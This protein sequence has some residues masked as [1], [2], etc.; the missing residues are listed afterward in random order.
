M[1][2]IIIILLIILVFYI[3]YDNYKKDRFINSLK[4]KITDPVPDQSPQTSQISPDLKKNDENNFV[5]KK[6]D[7]R[8]PIMFV[9]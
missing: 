2:A 9:L 5:I 4:E 7:K 6:N 8:Q 1:D 3:F